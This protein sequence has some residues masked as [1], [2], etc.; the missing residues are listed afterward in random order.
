MSKRANKRNGK[1]K[2][3]QYDRGSALPSMPMEELKSN[4]IGVLLARL[5]GE[6]AYI[7]VEELLAV[8][9]ATLFNNQARH[10]GENKLH[11]WIERDARKE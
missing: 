3:Q 11:V 8:D 10:E 9:G 5:P 6:E 4:I 7:T 1:P 2:R